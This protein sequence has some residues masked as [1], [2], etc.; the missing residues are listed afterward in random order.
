M[1]FYLYILLLTSTFA[2]AH[3]F[4]SVD[5]ETGRILEHNQAFERW[6]PTSLTKLMQQLILLYDGNGICDFVKRQQRVSCAGGMS[7][8][9][10]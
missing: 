5:V 1:Y 10:L 6:Y 7:I 8:R 9:C 3:P 4:I 2:L